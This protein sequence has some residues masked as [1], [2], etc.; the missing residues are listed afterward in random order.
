MT[1]TEFLRKYH[2]LKPNGCGGKCK[3]AY[4]DLMEDAEELLL[5][6]E[7]MK[8]ETKIG[9]LQYR[10]QNL[11]EICD[12]S[13]PGY[14]VMINA[15]KDLENLRVIMDYED[16]IKTAEEILKSA[17][18]FLENEEYKHLHVDVKIHMKGIETYKNNLIKIK[19]EQNCKYRHIKMEFPGDRGL[20]K[21]NF[22]CDEFGIDIDSEY[23][24][25]LTDSI[26]ELIVE[27]YTNLLLLE[28]MLFF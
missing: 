8:L 2:P 22:D 13:L 28:I 4:W 10:F 5:Y 24:T 19:Q 6:G 12:K 11:L 26:I 27:H 25:H 15:L 16:L 18:L 9:A 17:K 1:T 21:F 3:Q 20:E 14:D 7:D 23:E